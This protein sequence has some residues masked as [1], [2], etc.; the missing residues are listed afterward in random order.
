MNDINI[1]DNLLDPRWGTKV[2]KN[3]NSYC[4]HKNDGIVGAHFVHI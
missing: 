4:A 3:Y 1:V 2:C